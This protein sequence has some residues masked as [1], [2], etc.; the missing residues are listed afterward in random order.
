MKQRGHQLS[1]LKQLPP[2]FVNQKHINDTTYPRLYLSC[3]A[4]VLPTRGEGWGRP[5]ME[6]MAMGK[7]LITTNW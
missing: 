6:A 2:V 5:Q 4:V 1:D 7:P 3:D